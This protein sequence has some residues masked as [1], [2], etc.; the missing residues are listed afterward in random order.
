MDFKVCFSECCIWKFTFREGGSRGFPFFQNFSLSLTWWH[1]C[2]KG[3]NKHTWSFDRCYIVAK[4]CFITF[5]VWKR[6]PECFCMNGL[7]LNM[8]LCISI[9]ECCSKVSYWKQSAFHKWLLQLKHVLGTK[10]A[11]SLK[12]QFWNLPFG[13]EMDEERTKESQVG[14]C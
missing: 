8:V 11:G 3:K 2:Q 7:L 4:W 5:R 12:L 6:N 10:L 14:N 13:Q 1:L 9:A